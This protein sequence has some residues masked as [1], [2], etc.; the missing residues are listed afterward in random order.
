MRSMIELKQ[1]RKNE[2]QITCEAYIEGETPFVMLAIDFSTGEEYIGKL[3]D[4]YK[5]P[6]EH[7]RIALNYLASLK[8]SDAVPETKLIMWY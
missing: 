3:P 5:R 4:E 7:I 6:P 2:K 8:N 1:I